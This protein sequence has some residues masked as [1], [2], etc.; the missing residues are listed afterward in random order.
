MDFYPLQATRK[1]P[2]MWALHTPLSTLHSQLSTLHTRQSL[3][4]AN[5]SK[6]FVRFCV[7][8]FSAVALGRLFLMDANNSRGQSVYSVYTVYKGS[9]ELTQ[10][11]MPDCTKF[12]LTFHTEQFKTCNLTK[13]KS[14]AFDATGPFV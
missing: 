2:N 11:V 14:I 6:P 1:K 13:I 8:V 3:N 4:S 9:P 7:C 5:L 10:K 12:T